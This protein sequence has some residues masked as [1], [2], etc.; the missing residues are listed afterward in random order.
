MEKKDTF[1]KAFPFVWIVTF[2]VGITLWLFASQAWG[3]SYVLGSVT[4]L[5]TMSMLYKNSKIIV[6]SN[7]KE[8][9]Q[10][11]AVRN[12][13]FRMFFYALILVVAGVLDSLE[14]IGT[15]I[16]LFTFKIVFYILLFTEK[17]VK[18]DD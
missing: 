1:I 11:L 18:L 14:V 17:E 3:V 16:G 2:I 6:Q 4:G 10:K 5:M 8:V 7:N 12:Y 9:A 15:M 13:A